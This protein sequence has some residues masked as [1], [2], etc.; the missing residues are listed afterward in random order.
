[1]S[2]DPLQ[3]MVYVNIPG[4][5]TTNEIRDEIEGRLSLD[6]LWKST[7]SVSASRVPYIVLPGRSGT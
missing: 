4:M 1:M 5:R 6:W 2:R 3:S 7:M